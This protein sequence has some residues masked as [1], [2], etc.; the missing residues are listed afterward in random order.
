[1]ANK[2]LVG[3]R[4]F[5]KSKKNINLPLDYN[6]DNQIA[7]KPDIP[8]QAISQYTANNPLTPS[9]ASLNTSF[10]S[11]WHTSDYSIYALW[12]K[13]IQ[14]KPIKVLTDKDLFNDYYVNFVKIT[15]NEITYLSLID[16]GENAPNL[17]YSI[18]G[19]D[20]KDYSEQITINKGSSIL[21][22]GNNPQGFSLSSTN[23]SRIAIFG[24][25][26]ISG[27]VMGLLDNGTG[28]ITEIPNDYCFYAL[29]NGA[30]GITSISKNFLPATVLKNNCYGYMFTGCSNLVTAPNLPATTLVDNCYY[31]MF[32]GCASLERA[33]RLPATTLTTNCYNR[34]FRA[35]NSLKFAPD[36]PAT[37]LAERCYGYMFAECPSLF[38]VKIA[39]TGNFADI[40]NAFE[41][42]LWTT[43]SYGIIYYN[44]SDTSTGISAIPIGWVKVTF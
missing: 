40:S 30:T 37:T 35:C 16:N 4:L 21:L 1:M 38:S 31:A 39:Y 28:T 32:Y 41:N 36:L 20:W 3:N 8:H 7:N 5:I 25:V 26:S 19:F 14:T 17:Q 2:E 24:D 43:P 13:S 42:W 23:Y 22:R 9:V 29:F 12:F 27:N 15:A 33:P 10:L 11:F 18:N 44:G 6:N 34:M